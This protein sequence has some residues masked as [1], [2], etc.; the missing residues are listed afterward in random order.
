MEGKEEKKGTIPP[1]QNRGGKGRFPH[2]GGSSIPKG[3]QGRRSCRIER[4]DPAKTTH[5]REQQHCGKKIQ[6][7]EGRERKNSYNVVLERGKEKVHILE[8]G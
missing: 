8:T 6:I 5:L 2:R 4:R 3:Q 1:V 7:G